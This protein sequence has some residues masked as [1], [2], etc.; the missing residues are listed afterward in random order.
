MTARVWERRNVAQVVLV[1]C[2]AGSI[3]ASLRISQTVEAATVTP[4]TSSSPWIRRYPYEVFL[5]GQAQHQPADRRDGRRPPGP[6]GSGDPGVPAGDQVA[7]PAQHGLGADQ[8]PDTTQHVAG[9]LVQQR[10]EQRPISLGGTGPSH[11]AAAVRGP[12]S[13]AAA[14]GSQ[15]LCP[16][17]SRAVVA[18]TRACWSRRGTPIETAQPG[19]IAQWSTSIRHALNINQSKIF[20]PRLGPG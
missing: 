4:R 10:G 20:S 18:A 2:G 15:P 13:D 16:E 3:P 1:R 17:R 5:A 19:I 9:H 8:Q 12:R 11:R 14:R 6:F 7:V